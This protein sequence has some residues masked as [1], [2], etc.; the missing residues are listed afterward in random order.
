MLLST[1]PSLSSSP[2][3]ISFTSPGINA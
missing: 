1:K 2:S 3:S